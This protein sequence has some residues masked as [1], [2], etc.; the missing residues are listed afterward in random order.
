MSS[1][2][3]VQVLFASLIIYADIVNPIVDG[4]SFFLSLLHAFELNDIEIVFCVKIFQSG[5][6]LQEIAFFWCYTHKGTAK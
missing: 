4:E 2:K 1:T 3:L 6:W 5:W